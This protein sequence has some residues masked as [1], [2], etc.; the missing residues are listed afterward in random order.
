MYYTRLYAP[1]K[2][3]IEK[4][5]NARIY[6]PIIQYCPPVIKPQLPADTEHTELEMFTFYI[7]SL[8]N[9]LPFD[10]FFFDDYN[11][12]EINAIYEEYRVIMTV[13]AQEIYEKYRTLAAL[14]PT[15]DTELSLAPY[16]NN[17]DMTTD[18]DTNTTDT[19]TG[20]IGVDRNYSQHQQRS[21]S[22]TYTKTT[23][24]ASDE[25]PNEWHHSMQEQYNQGANRTLNDNV[26][27]HSVTDRTTFNTLV[28]GTSDNSTIHKYGF[29]TN[30]SIP[31][32][33][34]KIRVLASHELFDEW[35]R[36]M[37]GTITLSTFM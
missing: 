9:M 14:Q 11:Q 16:L 13:K 26:S 4:Y 36:E 5:P 8:Y 29:W 19:K 35:I 37:L 34:E 23:D 25:N 27:G 17:Y 24:V 18:F 30:Q 31:D 33:M 7:N 32:T 6:A 1:I 12:T 10:K 21:E 20:S 3:W 2:K 28:R 15:L 22:L